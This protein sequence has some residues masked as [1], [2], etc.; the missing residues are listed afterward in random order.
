MSGRHFQNK[1]L[2]LF[3]VFDHATLVSPYS[4]FFL[5][6]CC[7]IVIAML[8]KI[9]SQDVCTPA[10]LASKLLLKI[11]TKTSDLLLGTY[12]VLVGT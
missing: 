5:A 11:V 3:C 9:L 7:V 6:I 12:S 4:D 2:L 8:L 1:P 10:C